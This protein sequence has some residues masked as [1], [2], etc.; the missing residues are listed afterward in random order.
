LG[1]FADF[2]GAE[3][4]VYGLIGH[5][6]I[7]V[8]GTIVAV[9]RPRVP[10]SLE[11]GAEFSDNQWIITPGGSVEYGPSYEGSKHLSFNGMPSF[12]FRRLGEAAADIRPF[13]EPERMKPDFGLNRDG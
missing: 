4:G 13:V 1:S 7:P 11:P 5:G 2:R 6:A 10:F 3:Q 9:D 8:G 12:D